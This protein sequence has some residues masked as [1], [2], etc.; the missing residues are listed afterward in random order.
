M[1]SVRFPDCYFWDAFSFP[2]GGRGLVGCVSFNLGCVWVRVLETASTCG[3]FLVCWLD[4][5]CLSVRCCWRGPFL[6]AGTVRFC[7]HRSLIRYW[8]IYG[9]ALP[10]LLSNRDGFTRPHALSSERSLTLTFPFFIS[11]VCFFFFRE[12]PFLPRFPTEVYRDVYCHL[13]V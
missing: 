8:G 9:C 10:F 5:G 7:G 4:D 11:R 1:W 12:S 6:C 3:W 2:Y 13:R